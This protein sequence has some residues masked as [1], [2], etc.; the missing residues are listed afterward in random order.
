MH[1]TSTGKVLLAFSP[2]DELA[3]LVG[4]SG[5][6]RLPRHTDT[7]DHLASPGSRRSSP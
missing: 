6:G 3:T 5:R 1:A 2:P 4:V 7:D